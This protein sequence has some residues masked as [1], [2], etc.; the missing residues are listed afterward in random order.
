MAGESPAKGEG[1]KALSHA[2]NVYAQA[3]SGLTGYPVPLVAVK[4]AYR[5]AK[6]L[7]EGDVWGALGAQLGHYKQ[8]TKRTRRRRRARR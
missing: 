2:A 6:A 8:E 7:G 1:G 4:R 5:G 3:F